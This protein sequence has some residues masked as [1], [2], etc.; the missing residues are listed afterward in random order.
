MNIYRDPDGTTGVLT[1]ILDGAFHHDLKL[2]MADGTWTPFPLGTT[3]VPADYFADSIDIFSGITCTLS[4]TFT[5]G[6]T[7]SGGAFQS[8][9]GWTRFIAGEN[10]GIYDIIIDGWNAGYDNPLSDTAWSGI[11]GGTA[12]FGTYED[13]GYWIV[14]VTNGTWQEGKLTGC[15]DYQQ[16][17]AN[18]LTPYKMGAMAGDIL[19]YY[20]STGSWAATSLGFYYGVPLVLNGTWGSASALPGSGG[21]LVTGGTLYCND[22]GFASIAG[23]ET[24]MIGSIL[25]PWNE[26]DGAGLLAMGTFYYDA[27]FET[28]S[29]YLWN[30]LIEGD[31]IDGGGFFLGFTGGIWADGEMDG[32]A[33]ALYADPSGAAGVLKS[34]S[35][36]PEEEG[37]YLIRGSYYDDLE[38]WIAGGQLQADRKTDS[39]VIDSDPFG[40]GFMEGRAS[41]FFGDVE[42]GYSGEL[43]AFSSFEDPSIM[44]AQ[45]LFLVGTGLGESFWGIYDLKLGGTYSDKPSI[46]TCFLLDIG[47]EGEFGPDNFG[48]WSGIIEGDWSDT[49]EL[50]G[51]LLYGTYLTERQTGTIGG[52]FYGVNSGTLESGTFIGESI[53]T[54]NGHDL[55]FSGRVF[56]DLY[57]PSSEYYMGSFRGI[58]GGVDP[59]KQPGTGFADDSLARGIYD[60]A[61]LDFTNSNYDIF[62]YTGGSSLDGTTYFLGFLGGSY[63]GGEPG[64]WDL[65]WTEVCY[66]SD[67]S[68]GTLRIENDDIF[69]TG[70]GTWGYDGGD[71]YL[72]VDE[73]YPLE[74]AGQWGV[75]EGT[76]T[77]TLYYNDWGSMAVG[78]HEC[79]NIGLWEGLTDDSFDYQVMGRHYYDP[80][81]P[82]GESAPFLWNTEISGGQLGGDGFFDGFTGG[83]WAFGQ[84]YEGAV[85]ALHD[86]GI[87]NVGLLTDYVLLTGD[88]YDDLGMWE[89][90]GTM[91]ATD[92][93]S[94][95]LNPDSIVT[96]QLNALLAGQFI[97]DG[98]RYGAIHG[99]DSFGNTRFFSDENADVPFT[100]GIYDLK[101][102]CNNMYENT[103]TY[104]EQEFRS[105]VGGNG[106]FGSSGVG[107]FDDGYWLA[108]LN[109]SVYSDG[110]LEGFLGSDY[111]YEDT[112]GIYLTH[113]QIGSIEGPFFGL[114]E[115]YA[116]GTWIGESVGSFQGTPLTHA[117]DFQSVITN[118]VRAFEGSTSQGG[119]GYASY[120]Y[121]SDNS[122]GE[123]FEES[124]SYYPECPYS[125]SLT[126]TYLP[127]GTVHVEE[128]TWWW[129][130]YAY[131]TWDE[132]L[133][134]WVYEGDWVEDWW[135]WEDQWNP[136]SED[137][138]DLLVDD[139]TNY[140]WQNDYFTTNETGYLQGILGGDA[141]LW[142]GTE[143]TIPVTVLGNY[144]HQ[145]GFAD[146][147]WIGAITSHDF[148]TNASDTTYDGGAYC[149][150]MGGIRTADDSLDGGLIALYVDPS[151][152]A[153]YLVDSDS[154]AGTAFPGID[155]FTLE[156]EVN[157]VEMTAG[158]GLTAAGLSETLLFDAPMNLTGTRGDFFDPYGTD[159][160]DIS[161]IQ[162]GITSLR[163]GDVTNPETVQDWGIWAGTAFGEYTGTSSS[164]WAFHLTDFVSPAPDSAQGRNNWVD[165]A[166]YEWQEGQVIMGKGTLTADVSGAWVDWDAAMTGIM[167]GDLKGT[168]SARN[169]TQTW[170]AVARGVMMETGR[171]LD[172]AANNPAQLE[173]LNIP[174][175][176]V[177]TMNIAGG[178][179]TQG[180]VMTV[181]MEDVTFFS[182]STGARPV[183]FATDQVTGTYSSN[184]GIGYNLDIAGASGNDVITG[185][186]TIQKWDTNWGASI[187][188]AGNVA[189]TG[190][191]IRGAAAGSIDSVPDV[192]PGTFSGTAAGTCAPNPE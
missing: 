86:N 79:G 70:A 22:N 58:L 190:I 46:D 17:R 81:A 136:E 160:G 32:A 154:I 135:D 75:F 142:S 125:D 103:Y 78:G 116:G 93:P 82:S 49:G 123:I 133:Q 87:G 122:Y 4:G 25:L 76:S 60:G 151:G 23:H 183:I 26:T 167:G 13:E 5:Q 14:D 97:M 85:V 129:D 173:Q 119:G 177:G 102:G 153:G 108:T 165:I 18:F 53:G 41:G 156:G 50:R 158:T 28:Y 3:D 187:D 132:D 21:T 184:P 89:A 29:H 180:D 134:E 19:G 152:N 100:W 54:W 162:S 106:T 120:Y 51:E 179:L 2:F 185:T 166:G 91:F 30:S 159:T 57:D 143:S 52:A 96:G 175:V 178:N 163:I 11:M 61:N 186:M 174:C 47:G 182:Y 170:E 131:Q 74:Y 126:R 139:Y 39:L 31:E 10:W 59:L 99:E 27:G 121:L 6:G 44:P 115:D 114:H 188:G 33:V 95:G 62:G 112:F 111:E 35:E 71:V 161:V 137:L 9:E 148:I 77:S 149:G 176:G 55:S 172:M 138:A 15:I 192:F 7:L 145:G 43:T 128:R 45:T 92:M 40:S 67:T 72:D 56:A 157:R 155:M 104:S 38:M 34:V 64:T 88:Y 146:S 164:D 12:C 147:I 66:L 127:D 69:F 90:W 73:S 124:S 83:L 80:Y 181:L 105:L 118:A 168:F 171:F 37:G 65:D 109:G 63:T 113:R 150:F 107:G 8:D 140:D 141:S 48:F 84:L 24:G 101:F 117:S 169:Y 191:D 16:T 144:D 68:Y 98:E 42:T 189:G 130:D 1:G 94:N 20:D 110:T 36:L